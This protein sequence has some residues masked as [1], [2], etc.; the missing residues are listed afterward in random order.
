MARPYIDIP[1]F[2]EPGQPRAFTDRDR[3]IQKIYNAVASAGNALRQGR[4]ATTHRHVVHGYMGVGKSSILFEVLAMIRGESTRQ[5]PQELLD[6]QRWIILRVSGKNAPSV[7]ALADVLIDK[8]KDEG[9]P[10]ASNPIFD[11]LEET[12]RVAREVVPT[13]TVPS[14]IFHRLFPTREKDLYKQVKAALSAVVAAIEV[15]KDYHGGVRG[16]EA[17]LTSSSE[18][19]ARTEV[20][21]T[22]ELGGEAAR[23]DLSTRAGAKLAASYL[24]KQGKAASARESIQQ[25]SRIDTEMLVEFLNKFF[26]V[27]RAAQ[28][29]TI[30]VIDDLDEVT[31]SIGPSFQDRARILNTILAPLRRLKPTCLLFGLREEYKHEDILR[32]MTAT[33]ISPMPR[34]TAT[35]LLEVWGKAQI[36]P[37]SG[38]ELDD[39]K[40][41]GEVLLEKFEPTEPVLI[42]LRFL[43]LVGWLNNGTEDFENTSESSLLRSYI[44]QNF[45]PE[46]CESVERLAR[47]MPSEHINHCASARPLDPDPYQI[48]EQERHSLER[49][50][51]LRPAM[52]GDPHDRRIVLDPMVAYLRVAIK[53]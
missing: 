25:S 21:G 12:T 48:S 20:D 43:R 19:D 26:E 13:A 39:F 3:E 6:P 52:A 32:G 38:K 47:I 33:P 40:M 1:D 29:P 22:A 15:V 28:L 46:I 10:A 14:G 11:L 24:R 9:K 42:P 31:S 50:G 18:V 16:K 45:G 41:V 53:R 2:P 34:N 37:L 5:P 44:E 27:T 7:D 49:A 8:V 17:M 35:D 36:P 4:Q 30:L 51:L 23:W